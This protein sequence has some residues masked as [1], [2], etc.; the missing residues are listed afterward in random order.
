MFKNKTITYWIVILPI[1]AIILTSSILTY[2]FISFEK[3]EFKED[4]Q[5]L[6]S[7]YVNNL[8]ENL[9]NR[10]NRTINLIETNIVTI[11]DE[12]KNHLRNIVNIGYKTIENTYNS[13]INSS[14]K[15]I[16]SLIKKRLLNLKFYDNASGY[17]FIIDLKNKVL[18]QP[19]T[20]EHTN[21][22]LTKLQD[23]DGKYIIQSFA[24]IAKTKSEGYDEWSWYKKD[25]KEMKKKIGYIKVFKPL[26]LYIGTA[27]YKEDIDNKIK[28]ESIKLLNNSSYG[29]NDYIF[30]LTQKGVALTHKN[31]D[32]VNKDLD[33]FTK[34]EQVIIKNILEKSKNKDGAFL[35]YTPSSFNISKHL[36]QKISYI[37][38]IPSLDWIIGTGLYT[39]N[40]EKNILKKQNKLKEEL[41]QTINDI[42]VVSVI[43]SIIL[44][45]IM[46]Y[47]SSQIEKKLSNYEKELSL[48]NIHLNELN[49]NLENKVSTQVN[50]IREKDNMLFQQSKLASMG[51]MIGNIAHQWRQPLSTISTAASGLKLQRELKID[52]EESLNESLDLIVK[53]TQ[54]LSHTIDDF[55]NFFKKDKNKTDFKIEDNIE[56]VLNL[57][58]AT[59]KMK[60][61]IVIKDI[62]S[63][64]F[65]GLE[66]ELTQALLNIMNNAK[67][68][69]IITEQ[70]NKYIFI[71]VKCNKEKVSIKIKDNAKGIDEK[72]MNKIFEPYFTTKFNSNGTGIG[73][74]MTQSI[75]VKNMHGKI[76]VTNIEY[77]YKG[78]KYLGAEFEIV[79]KNNN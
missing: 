67:D 54:T 1:I 65:H 25:S 40:L 12:Q 51:E 47:I 9:K 34:K 70:K 6:K 22:I 35:E 27:I 52:S 29:K 14:K 8:K 78:E 23:L 41:A 32:L 16:I 68:A 44:I 76:N 31:K 10:I 60:D 28:Y 15:E 33:T 55:R 79:L 58:N 3:I 5:N 43:L 36:S 74:Y 17:F 11:K 30:T 49:E 26:N 21:K 63:C 48:K 38:T 4:S 62:D 64:A 71:S 2:R 46:I 13:N 39:T 24:N 37:K 53:S 56:K 45:F 57:M 18:M 72:I 66:N 73:L 61:I 77:E 19:Q 20:P 59:L 42:I 7:Y 50:K 75:I 69:L